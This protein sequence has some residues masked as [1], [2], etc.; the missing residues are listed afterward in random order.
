VAA[1]AALDLIEVNPGGAP[2][3]KVEPIGFRGAAK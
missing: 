2:R 3:L 1:R